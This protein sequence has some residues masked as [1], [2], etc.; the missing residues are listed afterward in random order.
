V[1]RRRLQD[2]GAALELRVF[3]SDGVTGVVGAV[4]DGGAERVVRVSAET[5]LWLTSPS[6][7]T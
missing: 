7:R 6:R 1:I 5:S 4:A 2:G 3:R